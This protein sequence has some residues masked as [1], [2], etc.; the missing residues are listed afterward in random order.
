MDENE[1]WFARYIG[2]EKSAPP[3]AAATVV[4]KKEKE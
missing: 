4:E 2:S 3:P 1:K